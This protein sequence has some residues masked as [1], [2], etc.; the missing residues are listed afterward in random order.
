MTRLPVLSLAAAVVLCLPTGAAAQPRQYPLESAQGLRLINV[1]AEPAT[2]Q[3]RKGLRLTLSDDAARR[4]AGHDA[5]PGR[6][7]PARRDRGP[8][9]L[10]RDRSRRRSPARRRRRGRGSARLRRHRLPRCRTTGRP[11]T[12]STCVR[13]TAAPTIRSGGTT[14]SQYISHPDWPWYRLRKETPSRYESYVD[15]VPGAWTK[16]RIEVRGD[17]A[18]LYV[19]GQEQPTLIVNDVKSGAQRQGRVALWLGRGT[20]AHFRNLTVT[21]DADAR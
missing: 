11:T 19:H 9:L 17:R 8:G 14:R 2:L 15:L 7:G 6:L 1:T 10:E 20:V 18:R 5:R 13:P 12:P 3:G 16:V 21:P 4:L